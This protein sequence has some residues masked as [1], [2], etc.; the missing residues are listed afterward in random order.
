VRELPGVGRYTAGAV[1][2]IAFDEPDPVVDGNVAR[3]LCRLLAVEG[4]PRSPE[5]SARLWEHAGALLDPDA[6]G[7][8]NQ[9]LMELGALV[10][11]PRSPDCPGCPWHGDCR[12]RIEGRQE[13]LPARRSRAPARL[14]RAAAAAVRRAGRWLL[15]RRPPGGLMEGLWEPPGSGGGESLS[16]GIRGTYGLRLAVGARLG[17]V[18][19]SVL[20]R[21]IR[22][23]VFRG[24]LLRPPGRTAP[25]GAWRWVRAAE[26]LRGG[27]PLSGA[28]RKVLLLL[29]EGR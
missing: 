10:C 17:E 20:D 2:S 18:R 27:L 3:V 26:A 8:F 6:P 5:V 19:H 7:D 4:D 12:A 21:R 15:V 23:E 1:R 13:S 25:R 16:E 14:E 22:L 28:G 11:T 29:E 9:A 24:R